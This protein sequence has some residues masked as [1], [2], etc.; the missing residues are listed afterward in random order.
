MLP[1]LINGSFELIG[2]V[3]NWMSVYKL[4]QHKEYKGVYWPAFAF[5]GLWGLWNLF[6]YPHL[7]Q[8]FSFL[9]G[10]ALV[11]AN[12]AWVLLA[13]KYRNENK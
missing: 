2:A 10:I 9:G 1:D 8:W 6:Y 12:I 11:S 13:W 4:Y 5:F 3:V 7:D